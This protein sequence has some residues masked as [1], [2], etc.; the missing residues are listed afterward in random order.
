LN[1]GHEE[2][3]KAQKI[4]LHKRPKLVLQ[5]EC[6]VS[7]CELS[8]VP[9]RIHVR[10]LLKIFSFLF[11]IF[12]AFSWPTPSSAE[13]FSF[14][15]I[16]Y[17]VGAGNNRAAVVIDWKEDSAE[18]PALAWGFRWD[19]TATGRDMLVA[20][21]V[22]DPRLYAKFG[23]S[24]GNPAAVYGLGYDANYD[25][26]FG[27]RDGTMFN[28]SGIAFGSAPFFGTT[29]NDSNDYYAEGW[30]FAFWHHGIASTNPY[31]G[32]VWSSSSGMASRVLTDGSWDS[33]TMTAG[34][35][36]NKFAENPV[37]A[38]PPFSPGDYNRNGIVDAAD[39]RMWKQSFGL[40]FN[41]PADGN[42]NQLVD[43]A[44]YVVWR[45]NLTSIFSN[46]ATISLALPEPNT[47]FLFAIVLQ[48]SYL[49]RRNRHYK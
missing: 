48:A 47:S 14:E 19:G 10:S 7:D 18:P 34:T 16:D 44:D 6:E 39:Y 40:S 20:V 2:H 8:N 11:V 46:N 41:L 25:G 45:A 27:I 1:N 28:D 17:W 43:A 37:A 33:W 36:L 26:Q 35:G 49:F 42:G 12:S 23:G 13:P 4:M 30:T 24:G 29:A 31:D 15:N 3:E 22:A 38:S 21:V 32:G 9:D 5:V